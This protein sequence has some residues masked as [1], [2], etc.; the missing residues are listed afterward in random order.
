MSTPGVTSPGCGATG[1]PEAA[2]TGLVI[3]DCD[4]V[5]ID[6]QVI[7]ARV[8]AAELTRLG[9]PLTA[10]EAGERFLGVATTEMQA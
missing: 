9:Y 8:D 5:L 2:G 4:G 1:R 10:E 7:Q 6:S 3:F